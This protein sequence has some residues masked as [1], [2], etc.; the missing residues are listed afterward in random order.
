[1]ENVNF[2]SNKILIID[3]E[4]DLLNL[5]ETY[6]LKEGFNNIFKASSGL[7]G[8]N[9]CSRENP[10]IIILDIMLPDIEGFEVC[11]RLR[12]FTYAPILFLSAK[13]EEVDKLLGLGIGGDDYITKPFSLKEVAFRIKAQLR[14]KYY[15]GNELKNDDKKSSY[16]F[17]DIIIDECKS[18]VLKNGAEIE[19]TAK[20]FRLLLY[21]DKNPNHILSKRKLYEAIWGEEYMGDDN[22]I[23]VHIRHLREKL[24]DD[25]GIPQYLVT[26][27]GL[28]YKLVVKGG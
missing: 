5:L 8:I 22:T 13:E 12:K 9:T 20:E 10:D 21:L 19:L 28:G 11:S 7:D 16:R 2:S 14:R 26:V 1:M 4:E 3:D 6:L 27:K 17:G 15:L 23:M 18:L 25:P 24:E